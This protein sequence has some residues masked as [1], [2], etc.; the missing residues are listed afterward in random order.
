MTR[1]EQDQAARRQGQLIRDRGARR[2]SLAITARQHLATQGGDGAA[3]Q[4]PTP[5]ARAKALRVRTAV[6]RL[7][8]PTDAALR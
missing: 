2:L 7:R 5:R 6:A 8:I 4:V 1:T 3:N